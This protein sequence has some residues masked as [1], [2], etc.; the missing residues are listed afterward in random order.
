MKPQSQKTDKTPPE[1]LLKRDFESISPLLLGLFSEKDQFSSAQLLSHV[2]LCS[3]MDCSTP[4]LPVHHQLPELAQTQ[5][6]RVGDAIQ[7]SHP[8]S[9]PSLLALNLTSM[10]VFSNESSL[11]F[12]WPKY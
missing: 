8:L 6:H 10:G 9:F 11:H 7:P 2:R 12:S 1:D 3:P 4:R 5:V